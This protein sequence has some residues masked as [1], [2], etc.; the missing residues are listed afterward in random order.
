MRGTY[1]DFERQ[2]LVATA[3]LAEETGDDFVSARQI[4]ERFI[5]QRQPSWLGRAVEGFVTRGWATDTRTLGS[6][7]DWEIYLNAAGF[8]AAESIASSLRLQKRVP[9]IPAADDGVRALPDDQ[10]ANLSDQLAPAADRLVSL[11]DNQPRRQAIAYEL[12]TVSTAI[13]GSNQLD[14]DEKA[15]VLVSLDLAG[16]LNERSDT[17]LAGAMKYLV[18]D[19]VRKSFERTIEDAIRVVV[20]G[21]L[22]TLA[23]IILALI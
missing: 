5:I 21:A 7:D 11:R 10:M 3:K 20:I 14:P 8:R 13:S 19:R 1:S 16:Q 6:E 9:N 18:F 15:N 4:F 23:A 12:A 22:V 2:L 17:W